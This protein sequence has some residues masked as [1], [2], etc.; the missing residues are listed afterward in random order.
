MGDEFFVLA[1]VA[2]VLALL[3][4][5]ASV[6]TYGLMAAAAVVATYCIYRSS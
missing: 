4:K 1:G 2:I 3:G 5:R 6:R